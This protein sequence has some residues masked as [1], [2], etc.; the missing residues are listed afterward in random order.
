ME[1]IARGIGACLLSPP[2][3]G[4]CG[5]A[6]G[7]KLIRRSWTTQSLRRLQEHSQRGTPIRA[8]SKEMERTMGALRQQAFRM[9][10][11]LGERSKEH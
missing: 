3:C 8:I 2:L 11:P 4:G 1:I 5:M 9:G 6:K 10:I 7:K